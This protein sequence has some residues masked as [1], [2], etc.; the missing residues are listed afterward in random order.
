MHTARRPIRCATGAALK[1]FDWAYRNGAKM[2]EELDYVPLP[3]DGRQAD[4]ATWTGS[5]SRQT[6]PRSG[7]PLAQPTPAAVSTTPGICGR[8]WRGAASA[9]DVS[10]AHM[11][12][13]ATIRRPRQRAACGC[14]GERAA[15]PRRHVGR[16]AVG[17]DRCSAVSRSRSLQGAWPALAHFKLRV[18]H[19]AK[20][21]NP[22]TDAVR[23]AR[24]R[25]RHLVT[26][27]DR[28]C[29]SRCR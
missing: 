22:V 15:V 11:R 27:I 14:S 4:R 8:R 9:R 7:R 19:A 17:A 1:F 12:Q 5:T 23:R 2:A 29:S 20:C 6:V 18:P 24:G 13:L 16:G 28:A 26:S 21:W 10:V 3:D 25:V